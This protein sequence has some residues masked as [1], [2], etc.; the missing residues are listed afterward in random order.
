M[1]VAQLAGAGIVA[2]SGPLGYPA[3]ALLY[4]GSAAIRVVAY[5]RADDAPARQV[6]TAEAGASAVA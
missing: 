1:T 4:A 2:V 3:F 6:A 5:R